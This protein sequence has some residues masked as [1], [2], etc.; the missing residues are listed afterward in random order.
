MS[1]APVSIATSPPADAATGPS[2]ECP[3]ELL[4]ERVVEQLLRTSG[5]LRNVTQWREQR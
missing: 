2:L 5:Q 3:G 4:P 1:T